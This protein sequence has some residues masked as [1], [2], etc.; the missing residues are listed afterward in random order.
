M[1]VVS[2][3]KK[4]SLGS[5]DDEPIVLEHNEIPGGDKLLEKWQESVC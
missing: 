5:T 2:D 1:R 3:F 4:R